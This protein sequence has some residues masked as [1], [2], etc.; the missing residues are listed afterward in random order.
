M[1]GRPFVLIVLPR[2]EARPWCADDRP[3]VRWHYFARESA[4]CTCGA[5]ALTVVGAVNVVLVCPR[6][7]DPVRVDHRAVTDDAGT[8][9]AGCYEARTRDSSGARSTC[10]PDIE[11]DDPDA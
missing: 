7:A 5:V 1:S 9:H 6:C 8:W 10:Q 11:E 4:R 2:P 3:G